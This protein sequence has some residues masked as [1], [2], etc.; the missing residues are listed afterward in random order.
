[1]M[2]VMEREN[3]SFEKVLGCS[4]RMVGRHW[5][6]FSG[7]GLSYIVAY[8]PIC[9]LDETTVFQRYGPA[10]TMAIAWGMGVFSSLVACLM[11]GTVIDFALQ[12]LQGSRPSASQALRRALR[13]WPLLVWTMIVRWF[14]LILGFILLFVP[15]VIWGYRQLLCWVVTSLEGIS[16]PAALRRAQAL[17]RADPDV[18]STVPILWFLCLL[19]T[20]GTNWLATYATNGYPAA[21]R[22]GVQWG[23]GVFNWMVFGVSYFAMVRVYCYLRDKLDGRP[24]LPEVGFNPSFEL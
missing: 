5:L 23:V 16:G 9:L 8:L 15:G 11:Y 24:D 20:I 14:W 1:M 21:L 10:K 7:V 4:L 6:F 17:M 2:G 12:A 13:R 18:Y 3:L 22:S 19:L